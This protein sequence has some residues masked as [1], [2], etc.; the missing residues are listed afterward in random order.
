MAE[1]I[2]IV[3]VAALGDIVMAST[4]VARIRAELPGARITWMC[5]RGF[6]DL[7]GLFGV[8]EILAIDE[9]AILAATPARRM[10]TVT[11]HVLRTAG[12]R[13]DRIIVAHLDPRYRILSAS[14]RAKRRHYM[15]GRPDRPA[16]VILGRFWGDEFARLLHGQ[17]EVPLE[18]SYD[19]IDVRPHLPKTVIG[20]GGAPRVVLV[21]GGARNVV[22]EA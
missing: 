11:G 6:A 8:D 9:R 1:Q 5:G 7:V 21:P 18:R 15:E 2:L 22:R 14:M 16:R 4:L 13:F 17:V 19:V 12:R 10:A 20:G 3:R